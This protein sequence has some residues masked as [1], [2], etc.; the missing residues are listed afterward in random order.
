MT[1]SVPTV[2]TVCTGNLCRSPL[3][4]ALLADALPR[5]VLPGASTGSAGTRAPEGATPPRPT[6][7]RA[8]DL[9]LDLGGHRAR[10]LVEGTLAGTGLVLA[11]AR[12]HRRAVVSLVPRVTRV[13]FTLREF[14]RLSALVDPAQADDALQD[15]APDDRLRV[16]VALVAARRGSG[17]LVGPEDD[18]V[19]DPIG[20]DDATYDLSTRQIVDAVTLVSRYL[21]PVV[22]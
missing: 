5:A 19:V 10:Q 17:P 4:A 2:L 6:L 22:D 8:R 11:M 13:T 3:A 12:E 1:P 16:A 15:V 9:G 14:A 20:L 18:D 7:D 21:A